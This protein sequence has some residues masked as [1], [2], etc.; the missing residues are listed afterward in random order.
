MDNDADKLDARAV[1][2]QIDQLEQRAIHLRL[3]PAYGSSLYTMRVH[4]GL[5]RS[6]L[7]DVLA[8]EN[9][10]CEDDLSRIESDS[11]RVPPP[12]LR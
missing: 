11:S 7:Q 12:E 5:I 6:H 1:M 9:N 3:P 2:A 10:Q 8:H 4:I